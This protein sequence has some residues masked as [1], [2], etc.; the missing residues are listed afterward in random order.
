M[1]GLFVAGCGQ[2]PLPHEDKSVPELRKMLDDPAP[3]VQA[4]GALGLSLHREK[5]APAVPR[6]VELLKSTDPLVRQQSALA[7]GK[8]GPEARDGVAGLTVTLEDPEWA[9]RRQAA[10][11]LGEIGEKSARPA[12]EKRARDENALVRKAAAQALERLR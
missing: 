12:L 3:R 5:A 2:R 1:V 10:L 11:A 7:L 6:L 8:I 4:Q 9:V